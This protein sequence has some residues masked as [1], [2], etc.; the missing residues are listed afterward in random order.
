MCEG[1]WYIAHYESPVVVVADETMVM[2]L[3]EVMLV[4]VV[5][6]AW[7]MSRVSPLVGWSLP[8]TRTAIHPASWTEGAASSTTQF[9]VIRQCHVI[10]LSIHLPLFLLTSIHS[11]H[12]SS[13][14]AP[15]D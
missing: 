2:V 9:I 14:I 10:S 8:H 4:V 5:V 11:T 1:G 15:P 12:T 6:I 7:K 13:S 3:L